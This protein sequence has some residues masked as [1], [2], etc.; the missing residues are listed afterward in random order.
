MVG[1]QLEDVNKIMQFTAEMSTDPAFS[2][3]VV[4]KFYLNA[5]LALW[6]VLVARYDCCIDPSVPGW[7]PFY[8]QYVGIWIFQSMVMLTWTAMNFYF[9]LVQSNLY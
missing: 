9:S 3:D 4:P 7:L 8:F 1:W 2:S 5:S 6:Y